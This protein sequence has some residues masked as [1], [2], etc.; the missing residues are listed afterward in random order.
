MEMNLVD[1]VERDL[2]H[3]AHAF[4]AGSL[5]RRGEVR[6]LKHE[7]VAAVAAATLEQAAGRGVGADRRD[8]LQKRVAQCA[9][10][11]AQPEVLNPGIRVGLA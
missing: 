1:V 9:Y 4:A 5:T 6:D 2:K 11:V 7:H 3:L 8:D 10:C